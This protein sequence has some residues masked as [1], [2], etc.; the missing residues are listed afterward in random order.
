MGKDT[1]QT[2]LN[3]ELPCRPFYRPALCSASSTVCTFSCK[4]VYVS[5]CDCMLRVRDEKQLA[6]LG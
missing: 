4:S 2:F 3:K 5:L 1:S 6:R